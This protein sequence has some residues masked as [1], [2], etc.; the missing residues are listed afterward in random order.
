MDLWACVAIPFAISLENKEYAVTFDRNKV[1]TYAEDHWMFPCDDGF[2]YDYTS[3]TNK[4]VVE[5]VRKKLKKAGKLPDPDTWEAVFL[6]AKDSKERACFI[7]PNTTGGGELLSPPD[8]QAKFPGKYQGR[9][10]IVSFHEDKGL[11]DCAHFVSRCLTT[12]GVDINYSYVPDL[13]QHLLR[14]PTT[15]VR[16]LGI[17]VSFDQGLDILDT[18]IMAPGDVIAYWKYM[19]QEHRVGYGHS[20]IYAGKDDGEDG[21]HR[22]TCHTVPRFKQYPFDENWGLYDPGHEKTYN[23]HHFV[24]TDDAISPPAARALGGTFLIQQVSRKEYYQFNADGTCK[25]GPN[26]PTKAGQLTGAGMQTG[27]WYARGLLAIVFWPQLGQVARF[28]APGMLLGRQVDCIPGQVNG[29]AAAGT[30]VA[31]APKRSWEDGLN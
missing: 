10:D 4:L 22:I 5:D 13:V 27:F 17:K 31:A 21:K 20:A 6:P 8:K 9:F 24:D 16:T 23:F 18:G 14:M 25:K 1:M 26:A 11:V 30:R 3:G 15:T 29:H 7:R 12:G 19:A 2:I 28:I